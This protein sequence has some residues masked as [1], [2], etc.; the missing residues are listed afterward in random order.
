MGGER[1]RREGYFS[2]TE[3]EV[4]NMKGKDTAK[5]RTTK[6]T[7]QTLDRN[8]AGAQPDHLAHHRLQSACC[9]APESTGAQR[10]RTH[11]SFN[12]VCT[13]H[14]TPRALAIA[15]T[16]PTSWPQSKM[17]TTLLRSGSA[18]PNSCAKAKLTQHG[19]NS[20]PGQFK[21]DKIITACS[22][23]T[24]LNTPLL[25]KAPAPSPMRFSPWRAWQVTGY[26]LTV[27]AAPAAASHFCHLLYT[28]VNISRGSPDS[29]RR[30]CSGEIRAQ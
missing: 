2:G 13:S 15:I 12:I 25:H 11:M 27:N 24:D 9:T 7:R 22:P 28:H 18:N 17:F 21:F 23:V 30:G 19:S 6:P 10:A 29:R 20:P 5:V 14:G 3:E 1:G 8:R 16:A 4:G 26:S